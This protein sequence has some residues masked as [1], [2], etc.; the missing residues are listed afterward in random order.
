MPPKPSDEDQVARLVKIFYKSLAQRAKTV[1]HYM[2]SLI[3]AH[4]RWQ[5]ISEAVARGM[6]LEQRRG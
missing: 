2:T 6:S 1:L 3:A 4:R 5:Q